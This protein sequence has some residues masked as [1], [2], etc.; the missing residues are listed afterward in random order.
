MGLN[1]PK[2]SQ[3]RVVIV[4][5]GFAGIKAATKLCKKNIQVVLIDKNNYH[6]FQPL[7]Y[8]VAMSGLEPSSISFPLRKI[9]QNKKNVF[10]RIC[11]LQSVNPEQ[12]TIK[13]NLGEL[14]FDE[15]ILAFGA[16]TNF[17]G[18]KKLEQ[19]CITMKST[20]D[21]INLRNR[22]L[23]DFEKAV[24]EPDYEKRQKY[25]DFVIVG[26][27]P[28]GVELAG[29][30]AEMKNHILPKDYIGQLDN[31]EVDIYLVQSGNQLLNGMSENAAAKSK[32]YLEDLGVNVVLG[33]RVEDVEDGKV[34][35]N[36]GDIIY[37]N[38]VIWA[39]GITS[40]TIDGL[41]KEVYTRGNRMIVDK[42]CRVQGYQNIWAIGDIAYH[43]T[44][45][46]FPKGHPQ[47]A[48]VAIQMG[49]YV[50]KTLSGKKLEGFKYKD[51]GSM[52]TIGRN[53]A[54]VDLPKFKFGGFFA[55]VIWLIVHLFSILG[56]K[57]KVMVF[58]NWVW[59][60]ITYDQSLRLIIRPKEEE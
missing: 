13:T 3:K 50:Y 18:N 25:I 56:I 9:F 1:I 31:K 59:N 46:D 52:A 36:N 34:T 19:E 28:T 51:K 26:G 14:D 42:D 22:I 2:T 58:L 44:D 33:P 4:G 49:D 38:K 16:K 48:Q 5:A 53:K 47:V 6:Q 45:E 30:I 55:W 17:Y 10:V 40:N 32:K 43:T 12:N 27:G 11:E 37:A 23:V 35:M 29:A 7:F 41:P 20:S 8:Q 39:A 21:A 60:Y 57:N 54:V 24:I 15:L